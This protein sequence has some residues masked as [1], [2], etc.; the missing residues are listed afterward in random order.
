MEVEWFDKGTGDSQ[1]YPNPTDT[2]GKTSKFTFPIP[3]KKQK[4]GIG[5]IVS[6][7]MS[8]AQKILGTA[9]LN[10][11]AP[12]W[13]DMSNSGISISI[14]ESTATTSYYTNDRALQTVGEDEEYVGKGGSN[15]RW[16]LESETVPAYLRSGRNSRL[17]D[18]DGTIRDLM[19]ET[20]SLRRRQSNSTLRSWAALEGEC[21][22]GRRYTRQRQLDSINDIKIKKAKQTGP[23]APHAW[24]T[25]SRKPVRGALS[26]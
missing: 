23:V 25:S 15:A 9:E 26:A 12:H 14:S 4:P 18:G 24:P 6:G 7:P 3:G 1:R 21:I 11:D 22:A 8:K 13:D 10:I 2:M 19:S 16:E 17:A 5:P 20:S